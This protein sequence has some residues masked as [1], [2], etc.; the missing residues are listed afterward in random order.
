MHV[1]VIIPAYH[2]QDFI[3]NAVGSVLAQSHSDFEIVIASD[4]GTDY[5]GLLNEKGITHPAMRCVTTGGIRTGLSNA[6]NTAL[7]AASYDLI[8]CLDADDKFASSYLETMLPYAHEHGAA[9][10]QIVYTDD[11]TGS[12]MPNYAKPYLSGLLPLEDLYSA[13][14]HTYAPMVFNRQRLGFGWIPTLPLLENEAFLAQ[15]C[16]ILDK[17]WYSSEP[18]YFYA[19]RE[20]SNCN[21]NDTAQRFMEA[22]KIIRWLIACGLLCDGN[23]HVKRVLTKYLERNDRI[24]KG[25]LRAI[26][27]GE[28]RTYQEYINLNPELLHT[29][30]S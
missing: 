9:I 2:A 6:R 11:A 16:T 23:A 13:C 26:Q 1:S 8:A 15:T 5:L 19:H 10:S 4:D 25:L 29:P 28:V 14:V 24:E 21:S 30:L 17:I 20:G 27:A 18:L 12:P 7:S 22:A 3:H